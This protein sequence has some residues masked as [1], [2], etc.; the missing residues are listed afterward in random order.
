VETF[1]AVTATVWPRSDSAVHGSVVLDVALDEANQHVTS[2]AEWQPFGFDR[3]NELIM[4]TSSP[5]AAHRDWNAACDWLA[6][7]GLTMAGL[8]TW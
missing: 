4:A 1:G 5:V 6:S 8:D 3:N 2:P 7:H